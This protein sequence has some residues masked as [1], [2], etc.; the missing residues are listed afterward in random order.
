MS[1]GGQFL[2]SLDII[3]AAPAGPERPLHFRRNRIT[4]GGCNEARN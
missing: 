4:S 1:E 2:L 3:I